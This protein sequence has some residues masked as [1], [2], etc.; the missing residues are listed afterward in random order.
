MGNEMNRPTEY[1][2]HDPKQSKEVAGPSK[3]ALDRPGPQPTSFGRKRKKIAK[4]TTDSVKKLPPVTPYS[5]C[6]LKVMRA[7]RL[8]DYLLMEEEFLLGQGKY[9][10]RLERIRI[11]E[12]IQ[13][14]KIRESPLIIGTIDEMP[15]ESH[16]IVTPNTDGGTQFY[17]RVMSF[18]DREQLEPGGTVLLNHKNYYVV[19]SLPGDISPLITMMRME[20]APL[21]SYADIGGLH[22][23]IQEIKARIKS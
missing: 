2:H 17:T 1:Q 14:D 5:R 13:L 18:V 22:D 20:K 6:F 10:R 7:D 21:E 12:Q 16:A 23:Q 19:G 4:D 11:M 15:D 9:A 3:R 8:R